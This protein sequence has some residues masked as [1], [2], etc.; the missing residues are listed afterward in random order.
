MSLSRWTALVRKELLEF[1]RDRV[2]VLFILY[3][4]TGD[5][6]A[7]A[8]LRIALYNAGLQVLDLDRSA[9]SRELVA[10]FPQPYFHLQPAPLDTNEITRGLDSGRDMLGVVVPPDFQS[11]LTR[12]QR[13]TLQLLLD[14][15]QATQA[16]LAEAYTRAIVAGLS[17]QVA[18]RRLGLPPDASRTL[19]VV[20]AALRVRF[21][22][23]RD[24]LFFMVL[25]SLGMMVALVAI[26]LSASALIREREHGTIEQLMVSPLA[27]SEILLAK[28][29]AST[30]ILLVGAAVAIFGVILPIFHVPLRGSLVIFFGCT[31]VFAFAMCGL[32]MT[33]ASVCR[34]MPQ[35]GMVTL[36]LM[37]P[38]LFLSG[39]WTPLEAMP[40]WLAATTMLSPLRW[41]NDVTFGLFLRGA[42]LADL[43]APILMMTSIGVL[44]FLWG[45]VRFRARFREN[46]R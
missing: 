23:N 18:L 44:F 5:L 17:Q 28:I 13:I 10:R 26:L 6:L 9:I 2:V 4:F 3:A 1:R 46:T 29:A 45:A 42:T 15:S 37:A 33:V 39:G 21:N 25:N 40:S 7:D 14:G 8:G 20:E 30:L 27:P 38:L 16:S 19:P 31:A 35:V 41:F 22:P 24:E 12:G 34:T 11:A 32:G 36:L 43:V